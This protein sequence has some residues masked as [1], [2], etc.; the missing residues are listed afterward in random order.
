MV[1]IF[2]KQKRSEI[3]A[4][5]KSKNTKPEILL[6]KILRSMSLKYRPHYAIE[7]KPDAVLLPYKIALFV[8]GCFW[9]KCPKC[10]RL[11]KSNAKYWSAKISKNVSRARKV[12]MTLKRKSWRVL[13][14][15][16]HELSQNP[17]NVKNKIMLL[18]KD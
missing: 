5:V 14:I 9:H 16:E 1:D 15:R 7:G 8:D 18:I 12:N 3:M 13:R 4:Q 11:P 6:R 2:S 17:D 10:F